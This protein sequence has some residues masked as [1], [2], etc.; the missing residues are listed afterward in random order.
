MQVSNWTFYVIPISVQEFLAKIHR[1]FVQGRIVYEAS[2]GDQTCFSKAIS[3]AKACPPVFSGNRMKV[4]WDDR[5]G[6]DACAKA[7][8][9]MKLVTELTTDRLNAE[10]DNSLVSDFYCFNLLAW[11][12]AFDKAFTDVDGHRLAVRNL[13]RRYVRLLKAGN[14]CQNGQEQA[15][16]NELTAAASMLLQEFKDSIAP[17]RN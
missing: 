7:L 17:H 2:E 12:S 4:L 9:H 14:H 6:M 5:L 16:T 15:A 10:L 11:K 8:L 1:L 13:G 3:F